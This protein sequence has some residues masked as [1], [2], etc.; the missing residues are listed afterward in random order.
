MPENDC[1][2][3]RIA[4]VGLN[5]NDENW[6]DVHPIVKDILKDKGLLEK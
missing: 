5:Y 6:S 4:K 3:V 1:F 2:S